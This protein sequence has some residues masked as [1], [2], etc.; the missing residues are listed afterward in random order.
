MNMSNRAIRKFLS[1]VPESVKARLR[2]LRRKITG[3][4]A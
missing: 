4:P 3:E 2:T 1:L